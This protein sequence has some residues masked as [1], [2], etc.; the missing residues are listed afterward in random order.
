MTN[1]IKTLFRISFYFFLIV[2]IA[3]NYQREKSDLLKRTLEFTIQEASNMHLDVS[4]DGQT[5]LVEFLGDIYTLPVTGG[6]ATQHTRGVANNANPIW[7]SDG[8]HFACLNDS[9][10]DYGIRISNFSGHSNYFPGKYKSSDIFHHHSQ[11]SLWIGGLPISIK[12]G[13]G[14]K[15]ALQRYIIGSTHGGQKLYYTG[16]K[17]YY[18]G[19]EFY[20]IG[21]KLYHTGKMGVIQKSTTT[22]KETTIDSLE[23]SG[24]QDIRIAPNGNIIAFSRPMAIEGGKAFYIKNIKNGIEKC[25]LEAFDIYVEGLSFSPD[26]K[27]IYLPVGGKIH[28]ITIE[29]GENKKIPFTANVKVDLRPLNYN[30][31]RLGHK[32]I[33]MRYTRSAQTSPSGKQLI[34]M[35]QNTIYI[36][37]LP[38]GNPKPLV[39]QDQNQYQPAWSP[40]GTK[41]AYVTWSDLAGGAL[42]YVNADGSAPV[43]LTNTPGQYQR[44][45]WSPDGKFIAVVQGKPELGDRDDL[46]LG[47]LQYISVNNASTVTIVD[48]I[49]L[50]NHLSFGQNG[51]R[52]NYRA[53]LQ[54]G[55]SYRISDLLVSTKLDGTD[56]GIHTKGI[57]L[58]EFESTLSPNG[59]FIACAVDEDMYLI[60]LSEYDS[61]PIILERNQP[62]KGIKFARGIDPVWEFNGTLGYTYANTYYQV[63]PDSIIVKAKRVAKQIYGD[64]KLR[65]RSLSIDSISVK[66]IPL[67]ITKDTYYGKGQLAF[68]NVRIIS[69][70]GNQIIENGTVLIKDGRIERIGAT[71]N[72]VIPKNY[73]TM[74]L[75]GKTII[76]GL[77]DLHLHMRIPPDVFPQQSW[78]FL[79]NLAYGVTT[80]RDPSLS[81]DS[82][83]YK[84]LL[85]TGQMLGPRLFSVGRCAR[86]ND[87]MLTCESI[88]DTR[89]LIKKRTI[90][91]ATEIKQYTLP[92]RQ[93][94]QWVLESC[95]EAGVNMTNEGTR[96]P[97]LYQL[98]MIKDGGTGV[99]HNLDWGNGYKDIVSFIAKSGTYVTPTLQ[100]AYSEDAYSEPA[101]EYFK[102]KYWKNPNTKLEHFTKSDGRV[103][104]TSNGAESIETI[105]NASLPKDT[106]NP[107]FIKQAKICARIY[108]AGGKITLGSHGN[109]QGIGAHNEMWAL[110]MGGLTNHQV[111]EIATIRGAEALGVQQD[112]GS[113]E[114]SKIAD[115]VILNSNPLDDI[116]NTRDIRY[117]MKD[118]VLY[119]DET[120]ETL[121]P[122]Q[123]PAPIWRYQEE[124]RKIEK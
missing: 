117:I 115:L 25:L 35:A 98:G 36:K 37:E 70:K 119:D 45:T 100:I 113:I 74:D 63:Y 109:N 29:T 78:M 116:H 124:K 75:S 13:K 56:R 20:Y 52:I 32:P 103:R 49:P 83:G 30:T 11:D 60:D 65:N 33:T 23:Y 72:M 111:L 53:S 93:Q 58:S 40:D 96:G 68:T 82:F 1:S 80:A 76:P 2:L 99:E 69:M 108:N 8:N 123:K 102:Y 101:K 51:Q 88:E 118:G 97:W 57:R 12:T 89:E 110:Q 107:D 64:N 46:G 95:R 26:S 14:A 27:Y 71:K 79:T 22:G 5:L 3:C 94:R 4:P 9:L 112:I 90:M 44:P 18:T 85:E 28:R 17:F 31:T 61:T 77:V 66:A 41:I 122:Y 92:T 21:Q 86:I 106:L 7:L 42:W 19:Q 48:S 81:Y 6:T 120:L 84:E 114:P 121:W 24:L 73:Q 54:K 10:G 104:I 39:A 50:R 15:T 55:G 34:F 105:M 91:G 38:D 59:R 67:T 87:G 16:S 47:A 62:L 43:K